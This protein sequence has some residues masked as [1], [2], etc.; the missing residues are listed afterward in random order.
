MSTPAVR[1]TGL[2][3]AALPGWA[4]R[5]LAHV[6]IWLLLCLPYAAMLVASALRAGG[7]PRFGQV[8]LDTVTTLLPWSLCSVGLHSVL[9]RSDRWH[10]GRLAVVLLVAVLVFQIPQMAY[11][12]AAAAWLH[13]K[14][15]PDLLA[16]MGQIE[17][18]Y[19]LI[20]FTLLGAS[21]IGVLGW[22]SFARYQESLRA[23]HAA[24]QALSAMRL[25]L[26][27]Q[28]LG[29]LRA[30]LE[31]HFLFNALNAISS[32][33]RGNQQAEALTGIR[34]LSDLL[35]YALRAS[36]HT[37]VTLG[38]EFDFVR[39]YLALQ[40]LRFGSKLRVHL[41]E[42]PE[43]QDMPCPPLL[44]QP[45]VENAVR[46]GIEPLGDPGCVQLKVTP[47]PD[48]ALIEIRNP[49]PQPSNQPGFGIGLRSVGER[50][51]LLYRG[52]ASL[53][54]AQADGQFVLRL[55]LPYPDDDG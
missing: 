18:I 15:I 29:L 16:R 4:Q 31:P 35:R 2:S 50:L 42:A 10:V 54:C 11:Q 30:Q 34:Q 44:L 24:E 17:P 21:M 13:G 7:V 43:R 23:R 27:A 37:W 53:D 6:G 5:F 20:D 3:L 49:S 41:E 26:E 51:A 48:G 38:D 28:R 12:H 36:A 8:A 1:S 55:Q 39:A 14:P 47:V 32:L 40:S 19:W 22:I 52:R 45:L 46:H 9:R 33:V 25:Q